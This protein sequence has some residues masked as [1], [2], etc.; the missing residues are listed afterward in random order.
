MIYNHNPQNLGVDAEDWGWTLVSYCVPIPPETG[1]ALDD[2]IALYQHNKTLECILV[3]EGTNSDDQ[4]DWIADADAMAQDFCGMG[5]VHEGFRHK[6]LES[7]EST[8]YW[9]SIRTKLPKCASV[10]VTGHSLGGAQ[11]DLFTTCASRTD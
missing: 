3:F 7:L 2:H 8:D 6:L 1:Q 9:Q 4:S 11:A 5:P 10:V